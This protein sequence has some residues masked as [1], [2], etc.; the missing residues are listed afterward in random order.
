[1]QKQAHAALF[2]KA[3]AANENVE[4]MK[5]EVQQTQRTH[6]EVAKCNENIAV[7]EDKITELKLQLEEYESSVAAEKLKRD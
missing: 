6:P 5:K 7:W 3:K 1:A 4:R 2:D